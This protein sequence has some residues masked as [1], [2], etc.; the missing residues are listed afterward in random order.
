[1]LQ[2]RIKK[3]PLIDDGGRLV[4]RAR[5]SFL[6][7]TRLRITRPTT[8]T[9]ETNIGIISLSDIAFQLLLR[10]M[11]ISIM[12]HEYGHIMAA[13]ALGFYAEIRSTFLTAAYPEVRAHLGRSL[14]WHEQALFLG[15]G[16]WFT[17]AIFWM[18]SLRNKD[19]ETRFIDRWIALQSAVYGCFEAFAPGAFWEL[20]AILSTLIAF[21]VLSLA[22]HR[23]KPIFII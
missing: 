15:A 9:S 10:G 6:R 11:T 22:I 4:T 19:P 20:G 16:G 21:G 5:R 18:M 17:A 2:R 13:R 1:M 7:L 14:L 12:V 8:Q 23:K 3:I